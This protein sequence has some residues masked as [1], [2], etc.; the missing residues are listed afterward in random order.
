MV[1]LSG[2]CNALV[3]INELTLCWARLVL[4]SVT[5]SGVQLPVQE[6]LS[7]YITSHPGQL[8]LTIPLWVGAMSTS[9]RAVM[10]CGWEV[11]A[12]MVCEWV[13]GKTV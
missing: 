8:R 12:G 2:T 1:L 10:L 4:G 5:V 7:Q 13:A 3:S 11:K 9:Q 6:S